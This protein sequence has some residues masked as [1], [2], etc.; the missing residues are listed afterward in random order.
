[1]ASAGDTG[2]TGDWQERMLVTWEIRGAQP[3]NETET[4]AVEPN[5]SVWLW[6][7]VPAARDRADVVGSFRAGIGEARAGEVG[8]HAGRLFARLSG[9]DDR[10]DDRAGAHRGSVTVRVAGNRVIVPLRGAGGPAEELVA[11]GRQ[12]GLTAFSVPLAAVRF[13][14]RL[15]PAIVL[16]ELA[17]VDPALV[18]DVLKPDPR[19][20]SALVVVRAEGLGSEPTSVIL[21]RDGLQA[22]WRLGDE[23][24]SWTELPAPDVGLSVADVGDGI[25]VPAN[26][27]PGTGGAF[28]VRAV[29][30]DEP[31]DAVA[32]RI[33]GKVELVGPW[34]SP[35]APTAAFEARTRAASMESTPS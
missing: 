13:S 26:L 24:V 27:P 30:P 18:P 31:V 35:G 2:V 10:A 32:V 29:L 9:A 20:P 22:H 1:V 11:L 19:G 8:A 14:A 25:R 5:G 16:P 7:R 12:L 34:A 17:G 28:T 15:H 23:S 33:A 6:V 3:T 21:A 4:I